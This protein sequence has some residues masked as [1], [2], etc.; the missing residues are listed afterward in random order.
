MRKAGHALAGLWLDEYIWSRL[1]DLLASWFPVELDFGR[2]RMRSQN[3]PW[4]SSSQGS[5]VKEVDHYIY[6]ERLVILKDW[7]NGKQNKLMDK[8]TPVTMAM[9]ATDEIDIW[10]RNVERKG[11]GRQQTGRNLP[12]KYQHLPMQQLIT[13]IIIIHHHITGSIKHE[14]FST[15]NHGYM[16]V[17]L[18][19]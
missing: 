2:H 19:D 15:S 14:G 11:K 17:F 3:S 7:S 16:F 18:K 5:K 8:M 13:I 12:F 9:A 6:R 1:Q 4:P 10:R